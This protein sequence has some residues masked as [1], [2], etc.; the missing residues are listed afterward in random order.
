MHRFAKDNEHQPHNLTL[1]REATRTFAEHRGAHGEPCLGTT[2]TSGTTRV[3]QGF[4]NPRQ[5]HGSKDSGNVMDPTD[6]SVPQH[7]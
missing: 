5:N 1:D 6:Y 3:Q 7:G 2:R 4:K